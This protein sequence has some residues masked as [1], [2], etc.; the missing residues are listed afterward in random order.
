[1]IFIS[2]NFIGEYLQYN[3][4]NL[5]FMYSMCVGMLNEGV[6]VILGIFIGTFGI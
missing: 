1:M 4:N 2:G 5:R 6:K 3:V